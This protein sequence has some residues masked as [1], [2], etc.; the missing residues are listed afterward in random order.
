MN[1][2]SI[3]MY[4]QITEV[5]NEPKELSKDVFN[6][7]DPSIQA[8]NECMTRQLNELSP[9]DKKA[10]RIL[11]SHSIPWF[12]YN[13]IVYADSMQSNTY[14]FQLFINVSELSTAQLY[15]WLGY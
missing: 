9:A 8:V 15:S 14:L 13:G 3:E 10:V 4:E 11:N 6:G 7:Y 12:I 5:N 1:L 2:E